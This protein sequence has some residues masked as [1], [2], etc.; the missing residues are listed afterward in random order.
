[1]SA[2]VAPIIFTGLKMDCAIENWLRVHAPP[3][4]NWC[5]TSSKKKLN[6][7]AL[8]S[9]AK[10]TM[11]NAMKSTARLTAPAIYAKLIYS[12]IHQFSFYHHRYT[13]LLLFCNSSSRSFLYWDIQF[14][15]DNVRYFEMVDDAVY[16]NWLVVSSSTFT[17]HFE[18]LFHQHPT[19]L[20]KL[21]FLIIRTQMSAINLIIDEMKSSEMIWWCR[22]LVRAANCS[23]QASVFAIVIWRCTITR[24]DRSV[25]NS[26]HRDLAPQDR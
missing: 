3:D 25:T 11:V 16:K 14:L 17:L 24:K 12:I 13:A 8:L 9:G 5:G 10:L 21:L 23:L 7:S 26:T 20:M 1:M 19:L 15:C 4:S 18:M 6:A 22:V 2:T